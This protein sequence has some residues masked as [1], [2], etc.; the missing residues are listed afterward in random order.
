MEGEQVEEDDNIRVAPIEA[1]FRRGEK[2]EKNTATRDKASK[3][4]IIIF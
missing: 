2:I 4:V 1:P 3:Y